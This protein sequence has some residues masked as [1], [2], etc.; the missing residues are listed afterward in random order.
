MDKFTPEN[1]H[2]VLLEEDERQWQYDKQ[3][4][5]ERILNAK[6][7]RR[8]DEFTDQNVVFEIDCADI[9]YSSI[10]KIAMEL[11]QKGWIVSIESKSCWRGEYSCRLKF[12]TPVRSKL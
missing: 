3:V 8:Y 4:L 10:E 9:V 2:I 11:R 12:H 6:R 1:I 5:Q 7:Q